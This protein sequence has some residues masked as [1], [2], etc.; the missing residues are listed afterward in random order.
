MILLVL[1]AEVLSLESSIQT[2]PNLAIQTEP[3]WLSFAAT[4]IFFFF[5]LGSEYLADIPKSE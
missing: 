2:G 5:Q 4:L 1:L 3:G